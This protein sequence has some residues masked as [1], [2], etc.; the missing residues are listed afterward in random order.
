MGFIFLSTK[1]TEYDV[2]HGGWSY[3]L[4]WL[5]DKIDKYTVYKLSHNTPSFISL[6]S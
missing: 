6:S 5:I 3:Q 4:L 2:E 1:N